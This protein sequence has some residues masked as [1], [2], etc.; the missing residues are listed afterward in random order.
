MNIMSNSKLAAILCLFSC[1]AIALNII[2]FPKN[3]PVQL[4]QGWDTVHQIPTHA[5]CVDFVEKKLDSLDVLPATLKI[6]TDK[7]T[8]NLAITTSSSGEMTLPIGS[9]SASTDFSGKSI[10]AS[11]SLFVVAE[12]RVELGAEWAGAA[13]TSLTQDSLLVSQKKVNE[14]LVS[15]NG[16]DQIIHNSLANAQELR[17]NKKY[18]NKSPEEFIKI[19]GDS[20]VYALYRGAVMYGRIE[21]SNTSQQE[22]VTLATSVKGSSLKT[23]V[24]SGAFSGSFAADYERLHQAG[25]TEMMFI[26]YG[27]GTTIPTDE[28]SIVKALSDLPNVARAHPRYLKFGA[29]PYSQIRRSIPVVSD[30]PAS[31]LTRK[32]YEI[33]AIREALTDIL[34]SNEYFK[35]FDTTQSKLYGLESKIYKERENIERRLKE[36]S[37]GKECSIKGFET[38]DDYEYRSQLP[39]KGD[40]NKFGSGTNTEGLIDRLATAR[41]QNWIEETQKLRCGF[42]SSECR[43]QFEL[44]NMRV[45]IVN[46]IR[47]SIGMDS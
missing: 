29:M 31:K 11:D 3:T 39:V 35:S 1:N 36:C 38:I 46:R 26:A 24:V 6:A 16:T 2:E 7:N 20:F 17:I 8:V 10:N 45:K 19:C 43:S 18:E 44:N 30:S 23:G 40:Y 28:A 34:V 21:I 22:R 14:K 41:W 13:P 15:K 33:E 27:A 4:G 25:R 47:Q 37:E 42:R 9:G 12:A 32:W 5:I